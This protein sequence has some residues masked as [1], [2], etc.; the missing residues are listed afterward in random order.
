M[1]IAKTS[2]SIGERG[3]QKDEGNQ[4]Q[5]QI[6]WTEAEPANK[7]KFTPEIAA[8]LVDNH[9]HGQTFPKAAKTA[10]AATATAATTAAT[11]STTNLSLVLESVRAPS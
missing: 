10:A 7:L 4:F 9:R 3:E 1:L 2:V 6:L 5:S 11:A 8:L